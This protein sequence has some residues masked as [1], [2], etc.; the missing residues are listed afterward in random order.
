MARHAVLRQTGLSYSNIL[1]DRTEKGKPFLVNCPSL[2]D[3]FDFNVS[4]DGDYAVVAAEL[5]C[6]VGVD[7]VQVDRPRMLIYLCI[8]TLCG[9]TPA[10][11]V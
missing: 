10:Y 8:L 7:T 5:Q 6:S 1:L 2:C 4:H 11:H 9:T 3:Q